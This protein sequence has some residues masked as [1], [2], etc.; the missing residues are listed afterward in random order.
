MLDRHSYRA[1]G[2]RRHFWRCLVAGV[3]LMA[4]LW[5]MWTTGRIGA[6]SLLSTYG[7]ASR[8][9]APLNEAVLLTPLDPEAHYARALALL[10]AGQLEAAISQLENAATLRP[11]DY[12]L[13]L[14]LARARDRAGDKEGS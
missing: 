5:G 12:L 7:M 13:W 1:R 9:I 10:E 6:S 4:C 2:S 3:A 11:G 8:L 14:E